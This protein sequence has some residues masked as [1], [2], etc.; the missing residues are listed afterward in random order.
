MAQRE[1]EVVVELRLA[2][3]VAVIGAAVDVSLGIDAALLDVADE[4]RGG[5]IEGK[6][7]AV[8]GDPL[9]DGSAAAG[10]CRGLIDGLT[11]DRGVEDF[12]MGLG[13]GGDVGSEHVLHGLIAAGEF[14]AVDRMHQLAV[15]A[16]EILRFLCRHADELRGGN[17]GND[18]L[19]AANAG[20]LGRREDERVVLLDR[21]A[22]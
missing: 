18:V 4:H 12:G 1:L 17:D 10:I 21:C 6:V 3:V 14:G 8:K 2:G 13:D 11:E 7:G 5:L 22:D 20:P 16:E 19:H 9:V 15:S